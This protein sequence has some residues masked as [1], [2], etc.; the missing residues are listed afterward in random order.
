MTRPTALAASLLALAATVAPAAPAAAQGVD[1]AVAC[2]GVGA[3][4][5]FCRDV[6]EDWAAETGN[7]VTVIDMPTSTT[8][9]L[10]LLQQL[11]GAGSP[12][13][14]VLN[15][16][17]I[18]PGLL[19]SYLIDLTPYV[20]QEELDA[21]FPAM[22]ANNRVDGELKALPQQ[23]DA[24][25]LYY[26]ADLLEAY[27][28]DVPETWEALEAAAQTVQEGERAAG[29]ERFWGFVWQGRAYEGLTCNALEWID[30]HGGG[31]VVAPDGTITVDNPRAVAAIDRAA[32]WVG[33][34]S[35][36][37]VLNYQEE[38]A[39]GVFQ[40][41]NAAFMRNW[42]YVWGLAQN[43]DSPVAGR[44]GVAPLPRGGDAG[45]HTGVLGGWNRGVSR[46]SEHPAVAAELAR[47]M[48]GAA[49]QKRR[50]IELSVSPTIPALYEDPEILDA[51]PF[52]SELTSTLEDA[53]A[54]PA[55]ATGERYNAVSA[56]FWNAV[57]ASLSGDG[58]AAANLSALQSE[59][60]RMSRG[61]RW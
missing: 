10:A 24:G 18:W 52:F 11:L 9:Q 41:G 25:L 60:T 14:D 15:L 43:A 26:R 49:A 8:E 45:K 22:L 50:A 57:H 4:G 2:G 46:F 17:V 35:P 59:L 34:I 61:G 39:R 27:G 55:A 53:V 48:T 6:A 44:I 16:D 7:T 42:P 23:T 38:E 29:N 1:I 13:I 54:R 51:V 36:P 40:S 12:D 33:T 28:L 3:G 37:G 47:Y 31:T 58:T 19:G 32:G 30:S 20:P 5:A 56:A 21:H